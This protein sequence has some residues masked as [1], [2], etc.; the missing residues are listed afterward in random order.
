MAVPPRPRSDVPP[1][2]E[3]ALHD[4]PSPSVPKPLPDYGR[5]R[6]PSAVMVAVVVIAIALLVL[7]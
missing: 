1:T 7:L 3:R 2:F 5:S 6:I 4:Q